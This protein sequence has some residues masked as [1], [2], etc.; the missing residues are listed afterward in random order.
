MD[1]DPKGWAL[2]FCGLNCAKCDMYK[3]GHGDEKLRDEILA[4]FK[5]KRNQILKPEQIRCEGCKGP[6][7]VHWSADCEMMLCAKKKC[8]QYCF[9]CSDFPCDVLNKFASDGA[10][11]HNR[12]VENLKKMRKVGLG[13]WIAEQEKNEKCEF[14][15]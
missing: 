5:E 6:L 4:W 12:T 1:E 11:H 15:P 14:C 8:V 2:A 7:D 3:A 9:E 13:A 10:A